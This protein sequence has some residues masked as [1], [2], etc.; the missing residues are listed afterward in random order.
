MEDIDL[1]SYVDFQDFL[2]FAAGFG[3]GTG[4]WLKGEFDGNGETDSGDFLEVAANFG[5]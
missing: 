3:D 1:D 2:L 4:S 5:A